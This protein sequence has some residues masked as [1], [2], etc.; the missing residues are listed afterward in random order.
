VGDEDDRGAALRQRPHDLHQVVGL[1]RREDGGR[2]VEDQHLRVPDQCLDDLHA[3]LHADREVLDQGVDRHLQAVALGDLAHLAA[4]GAAVQ[5]AEPR[6][7]VPQLDVLGD[8][9]HGDQHEVLVHHADARAHRVAGAGERDSLAVDQDLALV[10]VVEPVEH[11][12]QGALA[13]AVLPEQGVDLARLDDE[14]D[15]VVGDQVAEALGDAAKLELHRWTSLSSD[16]PEHADLIMSH[17]SRTCRGG[18]P[19]ARCS[20][21]WPL[22]QESRLTEA[23]SAR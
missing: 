5:E 12:H 11:V 6:A 19:A 14:V 10:G 17:A 7:L 21:C 23:G 3:L 22:A 9:E 13:G 4:G 16:L 18:A 20:P 2:L 15:G 1:L 8:G